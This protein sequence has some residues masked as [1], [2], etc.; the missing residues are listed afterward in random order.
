MAERKKSRCRW[1]LENRRANTVVGV[2]FL[3]IAGMTA[4]FF[5][6]NDKK[7]LAV[8]APVIAMNAEYNVAETN[9][10]TENLEQEVT[11]AVIKYYE[12]QKENS[13]YVEAYGNLTVFMKRGKYQ[14]T[15]V[16]FAKYDMKIKDIYT[17]VPGLGTLFVDKD[18]KGNIRVNAKAED[19]ETQKCITDITAHEDVQALFQSVE[20][21]YAKAVRSDAML[22]EALSDLK[23]AVAE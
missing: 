22:A 8:S 5:L 17:A 23:N 2:L 18:T 13:D 12:R 9:P 21:A 6:T 16:V 20:T 15:Y 10:L 11:E 1:I 19:V 4:L 14:N 7:P 3:M